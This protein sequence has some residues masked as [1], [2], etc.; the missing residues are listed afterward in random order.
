M[1][2]TVTQSVQIPKINCLRAFPAK[3]GEAALVERIA[4][5]ATSSLDKEFAVITVFCSKRWKSCYPQCSANRTRQWSGW[6][7]QTRA[8]CSQSRRI[9]S[10]NPQRNDLKWNYASANLYPTIS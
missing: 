7:R 6:L 8:C 1:H 3:N 10:L 2:K 9:K 5:N 4:I